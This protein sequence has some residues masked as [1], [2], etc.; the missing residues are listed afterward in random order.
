MAELRHGL[1]VP[2]LVDEDVAVQGAPLP[3]LA[4]LDHEP[5]R[6][7]PLLPPGGGSRLLQRALRT[8][9]LAGLSRQWEEEEPHQ[10]DDRRTKEE[11][12]RG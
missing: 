12:R 11:R 9:E 5:R 4:R 6:R 7:L 10:A 3:V 1:A 8:G 2:P